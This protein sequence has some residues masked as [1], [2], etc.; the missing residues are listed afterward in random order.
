[1]E[2]KEGPRVLVIVKVKTHVDGNSPKVL[3]YFNVDYYQV[4]VNTLQIYSPKLIY[5]CLDVNANYGNFAVYFRLIFITFE[6]HEVMIK[7]KY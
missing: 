7:I 3:I 1:M 6:A 4:Q 5:S 2:S